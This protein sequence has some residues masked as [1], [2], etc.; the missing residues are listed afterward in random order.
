MPKKKKEKVVKYIKPIFDDGSV[1]VGLQFEVKKSVENS[2]IV[3]P[4]DVF[5]GYK[6]KKTK[7]K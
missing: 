4:K 3:K 7:N 1:D 5:E 6:A 2:K